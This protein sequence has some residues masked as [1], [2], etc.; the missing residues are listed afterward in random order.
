MEAFL[1]IS[2]YGLFKLLDFSDFEIVVDHQNFFAGIVMSDELNE[3]LFF[4]S[5]SA[6]NDD[7]QLCNIENEVLSEFFSHVSVVQ[8]FDFG[9]NYS[10]VFFW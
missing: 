4:K 1:E 10:F 7:N 6:H 5:Q 2:F 9:I 8:V 3:S